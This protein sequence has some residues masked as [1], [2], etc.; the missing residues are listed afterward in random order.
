MNAM[1]NIDRAIDDAEEL[2]VSAGKAKIEAENMD[3][4]RKRIRAA[5]FV[6]YKDA[7]SGVGESEIR[8]EADPQYAA[9]CNDWYD[10]ALEAETLRAQAE[11]KRL[12]FEAWRTVQ[13]TERAKMNLR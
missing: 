9:A 1:M 12:R 8:A 7:G 13:S 5:M 11:A 3:L 6:K 4:R 2:F 10:A